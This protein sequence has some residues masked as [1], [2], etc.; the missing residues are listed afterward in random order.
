M[1]R[2]SVVLPGQ[3][4]FSDITARTSVLTFLS[5]VWVKGPD[6]VVI[7]QG[8]S[9]GAKP[10]APEEKSRKVQVGKS[11]ERRSVTHCVRAK[12]GS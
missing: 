10:F 7:D 12:C 1:G 5:E 9:E 8:A 4:G 6:L 3:P 2:Y 11:E